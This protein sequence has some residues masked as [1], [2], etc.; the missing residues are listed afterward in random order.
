MKQATAAA[1][2]A[3]N[4]KDAINALCQLNG[5]ALRTA[6]ALLHWMRPNEFPIID[7]RVIA[8]LGLPDPSSWEDIGY[9]QRVAEQIRSVA[10]AAS[11]DL[12]T[13]D[14]AL[15]TLDKM[16]LTSG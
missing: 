7:V 16:K 5:V 14:R 11:V 2:T 13:V 6:T 12:R 3:R 4:D 10:A 8:A 15:W 9:Y 1:F